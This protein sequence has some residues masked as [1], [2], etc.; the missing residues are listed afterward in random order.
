[1]RRPGREQLLFS[2]N[3][4]GRV[5][6]RNF[7]PMPM[8]NRIR[9]T[10]LYT[11]SAKNTAVVVNVVDLSV[12]FGAAHP[13][14]GCV[15]RRLDIDAVRWAIGCAQEACDTLLKAVLVPLQDVHATVALLKLGSPQ[16][17]WTVRIILH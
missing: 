9:R 14:F 11:V 13:M 7:E 12:T 6:G 4:V 5:K 16:W 8:S 17:S 2:I 10:R 15:L 1:M 3:Q